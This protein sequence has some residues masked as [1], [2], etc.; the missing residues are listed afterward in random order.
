MLTTTKAQES[1]HYIAI[2]IRDLDMFLFKPAAEIGDCDDLLSDRQ[3]LITL[4][5]VICDTAD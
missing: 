1:F 5:S 2:Q 3:R 4:V